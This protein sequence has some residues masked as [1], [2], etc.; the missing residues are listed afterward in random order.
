MPKNGEGPKKPN[1]FIDLDAERRKRG[2]GETRPDA[3]ARIER[4]KEMLKTGESM[5]HLT[6]NEMR[7]AL[8]MSLAIEGNNRDV[9]VEGM[10]AMVDALL[11]TRDVHSLGRE[12][13]ETSSGDRQQTGT[14]YKVLASAFQKAF[15]K[16][17][18]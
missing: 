12:L 7:N 3:S 11:Q 17:S 4:E 9:T 13:N 6:P 14:Y 5:V 2:L 1:K 16:Y 18:E 8:A 10:G 15:E